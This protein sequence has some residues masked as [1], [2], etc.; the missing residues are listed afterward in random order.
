MLTQTQRLLDIMAQLRDPEKGCPWDR[1]Q[2]FAT[3][4]PYTLEEAYE[5]AQAIAEND[6]DKLKA[7]LGDLLFQVVFYAQMSVEE[8]G[9]DF[10]AIAQAQC[11]KMVRRH[12]HVFAQADIPTADAQTENWERL[13]EQERAQKGEAGLLADIPQAFPA[14][15]RAQKLQ[16]RAVKVGFDWPKDDDSGVFAKIDEEVAE[17]REAYASGDKAAL[18]DEIG[19]ALFALVNLARRNGI[20]AEAALRGTN[21]K[22]ERRFN[23]MEGQLVAQGKPVE[24]MLAMDIEALD[25]LWN[26]AKAAERGE[27]AA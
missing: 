9:F 23:H 25:V 7:E 2:N 3:I 18:Q 16:K 26:A 27:H 11:D 17:V 20:D 6:R 24:S 12:P 13:K 8:G 5:V 4:A 14:L 22:F 10:D 1:E 21:A 15:L 19:D